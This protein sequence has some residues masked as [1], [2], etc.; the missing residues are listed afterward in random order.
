MNLKN[1]FHHLQKQSIDFDIKIFDSSIEIQHLFLTYSY[2]L[3]FFSD[4][5]ISINKKKI[6]LFILV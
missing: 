4:V 1:I 6:I 5:S 2:S 3:S